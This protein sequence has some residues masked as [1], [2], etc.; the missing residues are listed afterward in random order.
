L[1]IAASATL[2]Y[3]LNGADSMLAIA[4]TVVGIVL[5]FFLGV[6]KDQYSRK[7]RQ[8]A[9]IEAILSELS[10]CAGQAADF[11]RD[12]SGT[13][14]VSIA[15]PLYRLPTVTYQNS[16]PPLL[17]DGV[18]PG[19]EITTIIRYF[20]EVET[21]NRGLD[22]AEGRRSNN[23]LIDLMDEH[24]RNLLKAGRLVVGAEYYE[25]ALQALSRH[26]R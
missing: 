8:R 9:H 23:Q 11:L 26:V 19:E 1:N 14:S 21:L 18:M 7:Q 16:F 2:D 13:G 6:L 15:A 17:A 20:N 4:G 12:G 5:G 10:F 22:Q 24:N 25:P 3:Q